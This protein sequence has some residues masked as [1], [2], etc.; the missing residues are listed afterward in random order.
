M[1]AAPSNSTG[2]RQPKAHDHAGS[3][4][5]VVNGSSTAAVPGLY[6]SSAS[7]LVLDDSCVAER[8]LSKYAMGKVKDVNSIPNLRTLL[9]DEEDESVHSPKKIPAHSSFSEEVFGDDSE[10]DVEE[11]SETIFDDNSS[12]PNNNS[13]EMGFTP[14][15]SE[16]RKENDQGAEEFSSLVNAKLKINSQ[17]VYQ[18]INRE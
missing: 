13:D 18:E 9:M 17:E 8:D 10:C 11:V 15:V 14:E 5:N 4:L 16:I 12:S 6:I 1:P 3:Y 7:V 2:F